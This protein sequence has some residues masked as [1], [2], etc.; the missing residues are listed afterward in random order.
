M[1]EMELSPQLVSP[2]HLLD[3]LHITMKKRNITTLP[4]DE[5]NVY[6]FGQLLV[7]KLDAK[8]RNMAGIFCI[9][10]MTAD[11]T[12][13]MAKPVARG[14][15]NKEE[16]V[17]TWPKLPDQILLSFK[18][19]QDLQAGVLKPEQ[20]HVRYARTKFCMWSKGVVHTCDEAVSVQCN[21]WNCE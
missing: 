1:E 18:T 2:L 10:R 21:L 11:N 15:F 19:L 13:L 12:F 20:A 3:L 8:E 4:I 5:S 6:H 14:H 7:T 9:P 16:T 17:V